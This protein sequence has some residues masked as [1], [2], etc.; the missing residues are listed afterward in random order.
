M[1]NDSQNLKIP[2]NQQDQDALSQIFEQLE[3]EDIE[4]I[5]ANNPFSFAL[6]EPWEEQGWVI[7]SLLPAK[8]I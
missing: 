2:L 7:N 3:L 5:E 1:V 4:Q 8:N 6:L